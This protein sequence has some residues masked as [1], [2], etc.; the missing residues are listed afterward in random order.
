MGK[1]RKKNIVKK[2]E[3]KTT[4][5]QRLVQQTFPTSAWLREP[6]AISCENGDILFCVQLSKHHNLPLK[7]C[8]LFLSASQMVLP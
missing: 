5:D 1:R 2:L 6:D 4:P 8:G 7:G 3:G